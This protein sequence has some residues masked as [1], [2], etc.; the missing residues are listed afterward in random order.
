MSH[1]HRKKTAPPA[2][3]LYNLGITLHED[4]E[5]VR[6]LIQTQLDKASIHAHVQH[7][8]MQCFSQTNPAKSHHLDVIYVAHSDPSMPH[9]LSHLMSNHLDPKGELREDR[10]IFINEP[11]SEG[12]FQSLRAASDP[13]YYEQMGKNGD[14]LE[15]AKRLRPLTELMHQLVDRVVDDHS[16]YAQPIGIPKPLNRAGGHGFLPSHPAPQ[17]SLQPDKIIKTYQDGNF[18]ISDLDSPTTR[19]NLLL[20]LRN[21]GLVLGEEVCHFVPGLKPEDAESAN[22]LTIGTQTTILSISL[23]ALEKN[24]AAVARLKAY[25]ERPQAQAAAMS[26]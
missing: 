25:I 18:L 23:E 13:E 12:D 9:L 20:T 11:L 10:M 3:K 22:D 15:K 7:Y 4:G 17:P 6:Q 2:V 1:K 19:G 26:L 14:K 5:A 8:D 24:P 16:L 21:A